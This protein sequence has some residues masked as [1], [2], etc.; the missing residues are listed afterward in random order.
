MSQLG[1]HQQALE[2]AQ[3]ALILLQEE[4]LTTPTTAAA[5]TTSTT[6]NTSANNNEEIE[7]GEGKGM[8][9]E[10]APETNPTNNTITLNTTTP[11]V[12]PAF[13]VSASVP[14]QVDRIAVLAIA[15][16]NTGIV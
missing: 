11:I 1:R 8:A 16:H 6:N 4:L 9:D 13:A 15:Y 7:E 5:P 3:Q 2:H 12:S 10:A 14:P